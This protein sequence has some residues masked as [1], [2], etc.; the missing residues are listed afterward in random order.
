M[1]KTK[2]TSLSIEAIPQ[3]TSI[4]LAGK[5]REK[6]AEIISSV[7]EAFGRIAEVINAASTECAQLIDPPSE[8]VMEFGVN[9]STKG[10]LIVASAGVESSFKIT[11]KWTR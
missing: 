4:R 7:E 3:G 2:K 11:A 10:N 5:S 6:L 1:S 9:L 8:L